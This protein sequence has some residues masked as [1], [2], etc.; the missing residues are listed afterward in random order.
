MDEWRTRRLLLTHGR[1][2]S[3]PATIRLE[4]ALLAVLCACLWMQHADGA[5]RPNVLLI[6]ADDLADWH[7]GCYG[8][9]DIQTP[10]LDALAAGGVRMAN[11]FV[12]TPVCSPSRATLFSGRLPRQNGLEDFITSRVQDDPP[13]G[14]SPRLPPEG[15]EREVFLSDLF[16]RA[17]YTCG[18]VGKWHLFHD[19]EPQHNFD[20]YCAWTHEENDAYKDP[21]MAINGQRVKT[22]GY[23]TTVWTDFAVEY[24]KAPHAKPWFLTLCHLN[25]HTPYENIPKKY[26][27]LYEDCDF[28]EHGLEKRAD[29][30]LREADMMKNALKNLRKAAASTTALDDHI[31][32]LLRALE[33]TGQLRNTLVV[34]TSDHGY[35]LGRHGV[36]SKGYATKTINLYEETIRVPLIFSMPGTLSAGRVPTEFVSAYDL[37]P[38]LCEAASIPVPAN[39]GL[40]GRSYW[41]L[42][43]GETLAWSNTVYC[44]YRNTDGIRGE[45]FKL[46]LR[47]RGAGPNELFDLQDDPREKN[48]RYN[49]T[50]LAGVRDQLAQKLNA[51]IEQSRVDG[52][53]YDW[54]V[55]K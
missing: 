16:S 39:R 37:L 41:P 51:W 35:L 29:N 45:R 12:C 17:G 2:V 52:R 11:A 24:I 18:F 6:V 36:W 44:S 9:K 49:D 38:T 40:V 20:Y 27:K 30:A 25:P 23:L 1:F 5:E 14:H 10:A 22:K 31:P 33:E 32:P 55:Q 8:H 54:E 42:I 43:R 50:E 21:V 46:V 53:V 15:W 26:T 7:L 28:E 34:F 4:A 13:Q 48:N 47:N 3:I 19:V